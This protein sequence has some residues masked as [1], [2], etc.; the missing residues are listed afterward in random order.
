MTEN[1]KDDGQDAPEI[2]SIS[3]QRCNVLVGQIVARP[4]IHTDPLKRHLLL[5]EELA[6]QTSQ[7]PLEPG[8][9]AAHP[10]DDD[11]SA[12]ELLRP[13]KMINPSIVVDAQCTKNSHMMYVKEDRSNEATLWIAEQAST[14]QHCEKPCRRPLTNQR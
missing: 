8:S 5:A 6:A 3:G 2:P 11:V 1:S 4:S 7:P 9:E 13:G 12:V 14:S 10:V